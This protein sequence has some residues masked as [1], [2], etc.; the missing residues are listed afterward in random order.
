MSGLLG[1]ITDDDEALALVRHYLDALPSG[2]YLTVLDGTRSEKHT[3]AERIWNE[4][5]QPPYLLRSPEQM[6]RFFDGLELVE[7]GLVSAP[8]WRPAPSPSGPPEELDVY[9]GVGRKP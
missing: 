4:S 2:S 6:A 5:A 3:E 7:P 8:R 9:C 1:H